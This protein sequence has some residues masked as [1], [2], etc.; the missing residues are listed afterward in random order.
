MG[1]IYR[2]GCLSQRNIFYGL[3]FIFGN[4]IFR[5]AWES[6]RCS[7]ELLKY[8]EVNS[9][10]KNKPQR[11]K[12]DALFLRYNRIINTDYSKIG[13]E[14]EEKE[15]NK[16][17][18]NNDN[19]NISNNNEEN[20]EENKEENKEEE[21]DEEDEDEYNVIIDED[22]VNPIA[23][24]DPLCIDAPDFLYFFAKLD[25]IR[26]FMVIYLRIIILDFPSYAFYFL[27]NNYEVVF[28][29]TYSQTMKKIQLFKM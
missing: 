9:V 1:H 20:N 12:S 8:L 10:N 11:K 23:I 7:E 4:Y 25:P 19:K 22:Y 28:S 18:E 26:L 14:E 2:I 16:E 29:W 24:R 15:D 6:F 3:S 13:E 27:I 5:K 21:E 17:K